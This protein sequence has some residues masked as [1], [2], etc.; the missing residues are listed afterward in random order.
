MIGSDHGIKHG[1]IGSLSTYLWPKSTFYV[2]TLSITVPG[3]DIDHESI[4]LVLGDRMV[5]AAHLDKN[6]DIG[7][8][9]ARAKHWNYVFVSLSDFNVV[10]ESL[11]ILQNEFPQIQNA[12]VGL[13]TS[14][15]EVCINRIE[16]GIWND[17]HLNMIEDLMWSPPKIIRRACAYTI[18]GNWPITLAVQAFYFKCMK[19]VYVE[20]DVVQ[21]CFIC[22]YLKSV[23]SLDY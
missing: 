8:V 16:S 6:K 23:N 7:K 22:K 12:R 4:R 2:P 1:R 18:R 20:E 17:Y 19:K 3:A 11:A 13:N 15:Y 9:P 10:E 21:M 5:P 14:T